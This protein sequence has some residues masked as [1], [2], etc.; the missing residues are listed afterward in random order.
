MPPTPPNLSGDSNYRLNRT[1]IQH[2]AVY[3][4]PGKPDKYLNNTGLYGRADI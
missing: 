1:Q 4:T 2:N 3:T